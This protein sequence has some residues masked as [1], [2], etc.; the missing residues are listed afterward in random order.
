MNIFRDLVEELK[1]EN[2]LEETVIE[3]GSEE[4][5]SP[6]PDPKDAADTADAADKVPD[7]IGKLPRKDL[8]KEAEKVAKSEPD[9]E[10]A[11]KPESDNPPYPI[12]IG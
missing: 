5:A 6:A 3:P 8:P 12:G 4:Q 2:L 10:S 9:S 1:E 7:A 11:G